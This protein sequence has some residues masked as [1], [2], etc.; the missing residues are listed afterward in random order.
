MDLEGTDGRERGE[1]MK[2]NIL[3]DF[4]FNFW[5]GVGC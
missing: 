3:L 5:G 1:V 4:G 2:T